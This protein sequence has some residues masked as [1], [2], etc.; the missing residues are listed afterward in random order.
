MV[1][2]L[3]TGAKIAM[4][5]SPRACARLLVVALLPACL[6]FA[7]SAGP[8]T[9]SAP[10]ASVANNDLGSPKIPESNSASQNR[11]IRIGAGDLL[12]IT[13]FGVPELAEEVRVSE[14]GNITLPLV[15]GIRVSGLTV[16]EAQS[17][18]AAKLSGGGFLRDPQVQVFEKEYT[19]Q[20]ISVMGEVQKPGIY[21]LL[22]TRRLYD[23]IAAAGGT[24]QR[25]GRMVTISHPGDPDH[26]VTIEMGTDPA[27]SLASDVELLAGDTVVVSRAGV[28]YVVGDVEKPAGFVMDNNER[29]TVLQ[30]LA[31]AGGAK[32]TASLKESKIIRK[33]ASGVQEIPVP[34]NKILSAQVEDSPLQPEDVLFVPNSKAKSTGKAIGQ[35]VLAM[36][37]GVVIYASHP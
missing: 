26:P 21:T 24:S 1:H 35:A 32:G 4:K 28:V 19:S 3:H 30:A 17:K 7:Q 11:S 9:A 2:S 10:G 13:V 20:A 5:A 18:I 15:G 6:G 37:T 31:L 36:A 8:T 16:D 25:A 12:Q 22:G 23:A 27:K 14:T 33:S 29:L 34:L